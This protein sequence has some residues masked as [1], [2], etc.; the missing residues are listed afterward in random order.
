MSTVFVALDN[1]LN[2][3]VVVKVL[4]HE[5][6]AAVSVE[7]FNRE[8]ML[9]A[10]LQHPHVVPVLSA[11]ET[12]GL[13]F[14]IM[15]FVEGES[16]RARLGRGPLSVRE[17]VNI[18]KDVTRALVYAHGRDVIHRDIKPDNILLSGGSATVTDFGV[19]KALSVSRQG[20]ARIAN[21]V[22]TPGNAITVAG[23][24][25]GT[26]MYMAPEQAAGDP[27]L[28]HR[29]DLYALGIVAYEMLI[30]TPPFHGRSRQQLLAAQL[31]EPPPPISARRYDVPSALVRLIMKL[32]EKERQH[33]PRTAAE[34]AR[35][36]DDPEMVMGDAAPR[37]SEGLLPPHRRRPMIIFVLAAALLAGILLYF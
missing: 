16:L 25:I 14:F 36:L 17:T 28:D 5:L 13:P 22:T 10:A 4:P 3:R 29:A 21:P 32:L 20:G 30:G 2:R 34:V 24:S 12:E 18:L 27:N 35:K 6:A 8:I 7:R 15:P 11:G 37:P 1:S 26:P 19:A 33:R 23:T 31:T 9:L